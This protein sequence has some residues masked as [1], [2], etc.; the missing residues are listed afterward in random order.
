VKNN[1]K[2]SVLVPIRKGSLRVPS[3][4]TRVFSNIKGG[5]TFIKISQLLQ[6]KN[7][8]TIIIS[9][10]DDDVKEIARSFD[11]NNIV[12][13]NR[14]DELAL[15]ETTTKQLIDYM[16]SL[17]KDGVVVWTHATSPFVDSFIYENAIEMYLRNLN[18]F[19]SLMTAT[20]LQKFIWNNA[21]PVN[22]DKNKENW[23]QTQT[24]NEL[25][26]INSGIFIV[27]IDVYQKYSDRIGGTPFLYNLNRLQ[28]MDIDWEEDFE[29]AEELWSKYGRM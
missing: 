20:K 16:F 17:V 23:P 15:S 5:L 21:G 1:Q 29:I 18:K 12:I 9:T 26:E 14:P 19:D 25:H 2:I 27:S 11:S 6:V 10:D 13:D 24:I 3:K 22:Y 28:G 4:N 7:L 8:D